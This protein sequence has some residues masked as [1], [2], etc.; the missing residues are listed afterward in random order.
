MKAFFLGHVL[1]LNKVTINTSE[2]VSGVSELSEWVE[3]VSE[4]LS[5]VGEW[6]DWVECV[7]EWVEWVSEWIEWSEW[8]ECVSEWSVWVSGVC[9]WSEWVEWVSRVSEWS[10][11]ACTWD[12]SDLIKQPKNFIGQEYQIINNFWNYILHA[13]GSVVCSRDPWSQQ[14]IMKLRK[15]NIRKRTMQII[16]KGKES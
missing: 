15:R 7:C 9:E 16:I 8:V 2:W 14:W 6:V 10:D 11:G 3:W 1:W 5:G 12:P 4:W 13:S